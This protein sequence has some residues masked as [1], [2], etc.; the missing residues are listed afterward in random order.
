[1]S[2][3]QVM[4]SE[5]DIGPDSDWSRVQGQLS[6]LAAFSAVKP[7]EERQQLFQEYTADL[8]VSSSSIQ[9]LHS[10]SLSN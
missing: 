5:S 2:W 10:H 9:S 1:M 4:L 8:Q 7:G 3:M 6:S